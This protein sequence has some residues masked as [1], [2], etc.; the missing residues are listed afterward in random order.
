MDVPA[1]G[2]ECAEV[3]VPEVEG[4]L[5][6]PLAEDEPAPVDEEQ[7]GDR[8]V[9]RD[10]RRVWVV[11]IKLDGCA[12]QYIAVMKHGM[13]AYLV[14]LG[15]SELEGFAWMVLDH[16]TLSLKELHEG[17]LGCQ[18]A[19]IMVPVVGN[20]HVVLHGKIA[21]WARPQLRYRCP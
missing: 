9:R 5:L 4:R 12:D 2:E 11:N 6:F 3:A 18:P 1:F 19:S 17:K 16:G 7:N 20:S 21:Y 14:P 10:R 8:A 15:I 13:L